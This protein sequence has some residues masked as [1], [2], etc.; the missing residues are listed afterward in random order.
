MSF[1]VKLAP[2]A[3]NDLERFDIWLTARVPQIAIEVSDL[4]EEAMG[5]LSDYPFRGRPIDAS[6]REL[7]VRF[8]RDGYII[9]YEVSESEVMVTRIWHSLE[10]R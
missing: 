7:T 1:L 8:G 6:L 5:S 2:E 10:D 4:L 9:R 3:F